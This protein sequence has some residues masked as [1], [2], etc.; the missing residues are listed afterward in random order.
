MA[1]LGIR[2][3]WLYK[4]KWLRRIGHN[5]WLHKYFEPIII[6]RVARRLEL[7]LKRIEKDEE[8]CRIAFLEE[9]EQCLKKEK[10]KDG[11]TIR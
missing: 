1:R 3:L 7:S 9:I 8:R 11:D 4:T 6:K 2:T 5:K 10:D